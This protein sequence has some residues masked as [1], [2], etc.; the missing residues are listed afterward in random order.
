MFCS[1]LS[2]VHSQ[3]LQIASEGLAQQRLLQR[4]KPGN[5]ALVEASEAL[6]F[7]AQGLELFS[8]RVLT[9]Q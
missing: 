6:G 2:F 7:F 8:E 3:T 1:G 5:F 9:L 4:F